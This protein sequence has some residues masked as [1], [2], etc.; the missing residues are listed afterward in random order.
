MLCLPI[1]SPSITF[2]KRLFQIFYE[3]EFADE[4]S[5]KEIDLLIGF[6]LY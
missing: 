6:D 4:G 1:S 2:L 3:I 5:E